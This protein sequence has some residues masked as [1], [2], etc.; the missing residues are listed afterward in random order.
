V[1]GFEYIR[2][3]S[4]HSRLFGGGADS[5]RGWLREVWV[6]KDD[7]GLIR[8]SDSPEAFFD[9]PERCG[10]QA[11]GSPALDSG[12]SDYLFAPGCL[13]RRGR[14][15]RGQGETREM[16][17]LYELID[18]FGDAVAQPEACRAGFEAAVQLSGVQV[19]AEQRDQMGRVGPGLCLVGERQRIEAVFASDLSQ[20]LGYHQVVGE[21]DDGPAQ[22]VMWTAY[23]QRNIEETLPADAREIP[24]L[25]CEADNSQVLSIAPGLAIRIGATVSPPEQLEMLRAAG[26]I[27]EAEHETA[28]ARQGMTAHGSEAAVHAAEPVPEWFMHEVLDPV[29]SDLQQPHPVDLELRFEPRGDG[30]LVRFRERGEPGSFGLGIGRQSASRELLM[31][32]F[33]DQLQEQ[34]FPETRA[35][36]G[37]ARPTCPGHPHPATPVLLDDQAWWACPVDQ[38]RIARIG[39]LHHQASTD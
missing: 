24:R 23:L 12:P 20:L 29:L 22:L 6:G 17:C 1:P 9:E 4:A 39:Q 14:L 13:G 35:A 15:F 10:W 21:S 31:V 37:E 36:W 7:S 33:A 2:S 30:G 26:T 38:S 18:T 11:A 32:Q 5:S 28:L 3:C 25:P 27:T 34:F 19:V 8:S 16:E